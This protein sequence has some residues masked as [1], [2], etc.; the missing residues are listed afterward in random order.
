M[1]G[2]KIAYLVE[3]VNTERLP[4]VDPER[5]ISSLISR[6]V[7]DEEPAFKNEY[8]PVHNAY[9]IPIKPDDSVKKIGFGEFSIPFLKTADIR[10]IFN[11]EKKAKNYGEGIM[12]LRLVKGQLER[13][14]EDEDSF[15]TDDSN[16]DWRV[17]SVMRKIENMKDEIAL[18]ENHR[19]V[20]VFRVAVTIMC[21][22]TVFLGVKML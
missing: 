6:I 16:E 3:G 21:L 13:V 9:R 14:D 10:D 8:D 20:G 11:L 12:I 5:T 22:F 15:Q 17:N 7:T 19:I 1:K 2:E 18:D 4:R